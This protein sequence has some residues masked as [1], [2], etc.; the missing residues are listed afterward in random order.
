VPQGQGLK[1]VAFDGSTGYAVGDFGTVLTSGDGGATWSG[2]P[3]GTFQDLTVVQ[4]LSPSVVIVGGGCSVRESVNGGANFVD[5]PINASESSCSTNVAALSFLDQNNGYV[6][7]QDG[8][9]LFTNNA[10]QTVQAK[11]PAPVGSG[12]G[13]DLTFVSPT[14]GFAVSGGGGGGLIEQTIDGANSWT[15]VGASSNGLNAITFVSPTTAFAVGDSNTL[16]ESTNGGS[17]WTPQPLALPA[18]AGPFNLEHIS[19]SSVTTCVISTADGKELLRTADGGQTATIVNPSS[20]VLKDVAFSTGNN[21]IGVGNDGATVLST[22]AGQT[23]ASV[24]SSQL[25]FTD[26][27][28]G[29]GLV[30]G[31][32]P[33][34]AYDTG[35]SGQIAVTTNA[36]TSWSTLR[37]PTSIAIDDVAFPNASTGYALDDSGYLH[38]TTDAGI[39]WASLDTGVANPTAVAAPG[40]NTVLLFDGGSGGVSRSTDGGNNF[41]TVGGKV[42]I[43]TKPKRTMKLSKLALNDSQ[44]IPGAVLAWQNRLIQS[45]NSGRTWQSIPL[46][47]RSLTDVS[48]VTPTT[49][50]VIQNDNRVFFTRNRGRK[51]TEI[52]SIGVGGL[53]TVSFSSVRNGYVV[54]NGSQSGAFANIDVLHTTNGGKSW[55]PQFVIGQGGDVLSTPS[56]DYFLSD[57]TFPDQP[58]FTGLF[59]TTSG[60]ASP[61][62]SSLSISIGPKNLSVA[63][64]RKAGHKIKVKGKLQPV[65]S[66]GETVQISHRTIGGRWS[67]ADVGVATNG[68]FS[69]TIHG[70]KKT[71]DVVAL[72]LGDGVNSGAGTSAGLTV[73]P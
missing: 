8:S 23:F 14:T 18:G 33:G 28:D 11:T 70:V 2:L 31:G 7:L 66:V 29:V 63:K 16:L 34:Y 24:V 9:I 4:E 37:V 38:K 39:S 47:G 53:A 52:N 49:G 12:Q 59:S 26:S 25:S 10:G 68:D 67:D 19:C 43:S 61:Q 58:G 62:R 40:A 65:T 60:G 50:Y 55:Q 54:D 42:V 51:W 32:A 48:F 1:A 27:P 69:Y 72:A 46:P 56:A 57:L 73:K 36:G 17:T 5:V 45:T 44:T 15:Q 6:E 20:Q 71:T 35:D 30:P 41:H 3:S 64:L 13:N 21:L 22:D